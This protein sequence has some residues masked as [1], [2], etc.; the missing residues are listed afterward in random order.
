[1]LYQARTKIN[2]GKN[3]ICMVVNSDQWSVGGALFGQ[4]AS[5]LVVVVVV[6]DIAEAGGPPSL[7]L[8]LRNGEKIIHICLYKNEECRSAQYSVTKVRKTSMK[9]LCLPF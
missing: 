2:Q 4:P 5:L 1:M 6:V 7:S 8:S 3:A 9:F